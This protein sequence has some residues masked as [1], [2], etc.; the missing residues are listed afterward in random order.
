MCLKLSRLCILLEQSFS[1]VLSSLHHF[2]F[3]VLDAST[4]DQVSK[5]VPYNLVKG[6]RVSKDRQARQDPR[7]SDLP[8]FLSHRHEGPAAAI[9]IAAHSDSCGG[10]GKSNL[11]KVIRKTLGL[12]DGHVQLKHPHNRD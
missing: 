3:L 10:T 1:R 7:S 6:F 11:S 9:A 12:L 4:L 5:F 2:K 8:V